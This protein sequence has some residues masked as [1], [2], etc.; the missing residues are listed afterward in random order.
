MSYD[1]YGNYSLGNGSWAIS[2]VSTQNYSSSED[3]TNVQCSSTH[4]TSFAVLVDVA[5][6]L[7][8]GHY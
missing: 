2:G 8:V 1:N 3:H 4:L 6:V 7:V 5:G